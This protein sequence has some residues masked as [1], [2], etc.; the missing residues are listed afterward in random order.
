[1]EIKKLTPKIKPMTL[2][3]PIGLTPDRIV[4]KLFSFHNKAHL[5]HLQTTTIGN[6]MLLKELYES[7]EDFKD[8]IAEYLLGVQIPTRFGYI[9]IDQ[10][11][12][13][14]ES[15]LMAFLNEGFEF[16]VQL[17]EY[18]DSKGLEQLCNLSS[19]LQGAF[20]K[21]KLFTTYK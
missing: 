5:Y 15:N 6:H 17:C 13:Y 11:E 14:S 20:V 3:L 19:E 12:P 16:S 8:D 1:M 21:A 10:V 18:A 2:E 7:L 9:M 4:G